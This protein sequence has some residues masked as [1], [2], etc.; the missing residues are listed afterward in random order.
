MATM[1]GW[2]FESVPS[3]EDIAGIAVRTVPVP[4]PGAGEIRVKIVASSTNPVDWKHATFG[5][6]AQ[7]PSIYGVDG[8]GVVDAL[9]AGVTSHAVG[10]RVYYFGN[11]IGTTGTFAEYGVVKALA[12]ARIPDGVSF[13]DAAVSPCAGW[14]AYECLFNRLRVEAGKILVVNAAAG[15]VGNFAVQL[16]LYKKVR[17]IAIASGDSCDK[18]R[19][20]GCELVIDYR[21]EDVVAKIKEFTGRG[22]DYVLDSVDE[23]S[24][25]KLAGVLRFRGQIVHIANTIVPPE[26]GLFLGGVSTH[27]VFIPGHFFGDDSDL[28]FFRDIGVEFG[29]LLA[30]GAVKPMISKTVTFDGVRDALIEQKGGRVKGKILIKMA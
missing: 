15:G 30:S 5:D 6:W 19:S 3:D 1:R 12:A 18:L 14:T 17:V 22:A 4:E 11:V 27:H 7:Y 29:A 26:D 2:G 25:K 8:A 21:T 10:D 28:T 23:E 9:G 24:A 16:A 13:E 20:M